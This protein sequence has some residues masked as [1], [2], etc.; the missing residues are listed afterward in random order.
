MGNTFVQTKDLQAL[1]KKT[2]TLKDFKPVQ[3]FE[4]KG[5]DHSAALPAKK[6]QHRVK[7]FLPR[8]LDQ[9]I[10]GRRVGDWLRPDPWNP[11]RAVC[12]VCPKDHQA[13]PCTF[14]IAEGFSAIT[15]HSKARKH[16]DQVAAENGLVFR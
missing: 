1:F 4:E 12:L 5:K 16:K 8:W 14:T 7:E 11:G 6:T 15:Q 13:N 3:I 10:E 9:R 2:E